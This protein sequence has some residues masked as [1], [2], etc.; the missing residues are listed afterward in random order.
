MDDEYENIKQLFNETKFSANNLFDNLYCQEC[1]LPLKDYGYD[2][3]PFGKN[4]FTDLILCGKCAADY[5]GED[6]YHFEEIENE[7][8]ILTLTFIN[9]EKVQNYKIQEITCE[10]LKS[11]ALGMTEKDILNKYP[12]LSHQDIL[13]CYKF[14]AQRI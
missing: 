3:Y 12:N 1:S 14:A 4:E 6:D 11:L 9:D 13:A 5:C 7:S 8:E 2:F 10:V